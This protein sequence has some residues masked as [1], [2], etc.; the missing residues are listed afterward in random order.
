M[1]IDRLSSDRNWNWLSIGLII[2]IVLLS[3]RS[4]AAVFSPSLNSDNAVH[5]L[6][7]YH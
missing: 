7:A 6:M 3:I 5:V 2:P 1:T 4:L